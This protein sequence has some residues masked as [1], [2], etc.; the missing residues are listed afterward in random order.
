[1]RYTNIRITSSERSPGVAI[2]PLVW[3][4]SSL[5][6]LRAFPADARWRAGFELRKVQEG[7]DPSDWKP[8][9]II[10]AGVVELRIHTDVE[11]RVVYVAKFAEAIYALHA[12]EK[13]TGKTARRDIAV[14]RNRLR[15][16]LRDR[17][18]TRRA[19]KY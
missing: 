19:G 18:Q 13:R 17:R 5:A 9:S 1:L 6:D 3:V 15:E 2:K 12:F 7:F 11:R 4:G 8:M 14:A 10:G 16:V